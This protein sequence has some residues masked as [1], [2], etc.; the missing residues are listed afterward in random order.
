MKKPKPLP[1]TMRVKK[2]YILFKLS[3]PVHEGLRASDV[4]FAIFKEFSSLYGSQGIAKMH[5]HLIE[6]S[7][8]N[9]S[10]IGAEKTGTGI[11]ILRCSREKETEVKAGLLFLKTVGAVS[12]IP[13]ILLVSG[14]LKKLKNSLLHYAGC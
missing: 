2:R 3:F 11:G 12:V 7:S 9:S 8:E 13:K 14:S 10:G 1:P 6:F 5:L 4:N